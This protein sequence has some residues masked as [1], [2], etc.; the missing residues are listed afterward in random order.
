MAKE[1]T[2]LEEIFV[3]GDEKDGTNS[4]EVLFGDE[5]KCPEIKVNPEQDLVVLP[6]SSGTTG[7]PKGVMLSHSNLVSNLYQF[8][9]LEPSGEEDTLI[10]V[11]PFY[12]IYGM[13]V[14]LNSALSHGATV[15]CMSRFDLEQ[16]LVL[17][18]KHEVTRA[19]VTSC[20]CIKTRNCSRSN[21]DMQTTVAP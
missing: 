8:T 15:V 13:T 17:M 11:L 5:S 20:F 16:F 18:Q 6:Y 12:H 2:S 7:H 10:A 21:R 19:R 9:E 1:S 3:I 4:Y 14:I